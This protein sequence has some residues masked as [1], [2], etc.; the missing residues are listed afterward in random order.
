MS[1]VHSIDS[2]DGATGPQRTSEPTTSRHQNIE[3][4]GEP[5]IHFKNKQKRFYAALTP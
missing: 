5:H 3:A 1:L 2:V 4:G